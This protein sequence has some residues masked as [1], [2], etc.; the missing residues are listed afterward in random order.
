MEKRLLSLE[1]GIEYTGLKRTKFRSW[2]VENGA[3]LKIGSRAL[4]DKKVIDEILDQQGGGRHEETS[5]Q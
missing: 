4:Y 2:A 5:E 1:E 3:M